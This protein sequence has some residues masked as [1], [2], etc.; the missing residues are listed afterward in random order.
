MKK[1]YKFL[2]IFFVF[3]SLFFLSLVSNAVYKSDIMQDIRAEKD[4][5]F[6]LISTDQ[7]NFLC[8]YVLEYS[9]KKQSI[10][11]FPINAKTRFV[12]AN[13]EKPVYLQDIYQRIYYR[14]K[15][16]L[17]NSTKQLLTTI[18]QIYDLDLKYYIHFSSADVLNIN[19]EFG[20]NPEDLDYSK[21]INSDA[22]DRAILSKYIV[23]TKFLSV[24]N[25]FK[26][27]ETNKLK[28]LSAESLKKWDLNLK[29]S[30]VNLTQ[31]FCLLTT[32]YKIEN[33]NLIFV[34]FNN[35]ISAKD[36]FYIRDAMKN[37]DTKSNEIVIEVLN[38]SGAKGL[39]LDITR[40]LR[41]NGFDVQE[42]GNYGR[43][44]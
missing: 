23:T 12:Q 24:F 1:I 40:F 16:N 14:N 42:W 8:G 15:R 11:V 39:A 38:G 37:I 6:L 7:Q 41:D 18:N 3:E 22:D 30:N 21:I 2:S 4:F 31:I 26:F 34:G 36:N 43:D 9:L 17:N 10:L 28:N 19:K 32:F 44:K 25:I 33:L 13:S 27:F 5:K 29:N 20:I 35:V